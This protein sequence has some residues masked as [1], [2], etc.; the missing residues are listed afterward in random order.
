MGREFH[1]DMKDLLE[2]SGE[3]FFRNSA[4][5]SPDQAKNPDLETQNRDLKGAMTYMH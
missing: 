2:G 1:K 4:E 3:D 5:V